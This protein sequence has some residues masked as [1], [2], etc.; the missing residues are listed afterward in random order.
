VA[1]FVQTNIGIETTDKDMLYRH[2]TKLST[3][4]ITTAQYPDGRINIDLISSTKHPP[5]LDGWKVAM[6]R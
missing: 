6:L 2:L 4:P 3:F 5:E 1:S